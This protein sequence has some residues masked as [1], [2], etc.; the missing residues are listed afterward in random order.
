MTETD[1]PEP[2]AGKPVLLTGANGF[3]GAWIARRLL[4][5]GHRVHATVRDANDPRKTAHL[6]AMAA[7]LPGTLRLFSADLT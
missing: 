7:E 4:E 2:V 1:A 5:E 6:E 3:V